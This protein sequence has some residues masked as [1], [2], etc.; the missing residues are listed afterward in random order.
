MKILKTE[1]GGLY[2]KP[3]KNQP[4][5]GYATNQLVDLFIARDAVSNEDVDA[6]PHSFEEHP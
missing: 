5:T 4:K 2:E 1:R 3:P 6:S